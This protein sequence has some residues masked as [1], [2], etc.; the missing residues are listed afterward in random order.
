MGVRAN[1]LNRGGAFG[2]KKKKKPKKK[3]LKY[4]LEDL[5]KLD[6]DELREVGEEFGVKF[7]SYSEAYREIMKAQKK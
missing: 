4:T 1:R 5:K 6:W 2:K 7:R 3:S